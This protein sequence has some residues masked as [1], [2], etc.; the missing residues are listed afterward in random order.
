MKI[1]QAHLTF[2]RQQKAPVPTWGQSLKYPNQGGGIHELINAQAEKYDRRLEACNLIALIQTAS[3]NFTDQPSRIVGMPNYPNLRA[4]L[5]HLAFK[6][7]STDK[8]RR[9]AYAKK[10]YVRLTT[11]SYG[12]ARRLEGE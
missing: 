10:W 11:G 8:P 5:F 12:L 1:T 7:Y 2:Y 4:F 6:P 3:R 9:T